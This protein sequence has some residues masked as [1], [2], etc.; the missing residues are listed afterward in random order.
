MTELFLIIL[1]ENSFKN[2]KKK[3]IWKKRKYYK[4]ISSKTIKTGKPKVTHHD[5]VFTLMDWTAV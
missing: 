2:V 1:K 3:I 5:P 4:L